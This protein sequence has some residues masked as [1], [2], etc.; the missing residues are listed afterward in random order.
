MNFRNLAI[1]SGLEFTDTELAQLE[2]D[3][4]EALARVAPIL[5]C[6]P[7]DV[8]IFPDAVNLSD[9][10]DDVHEQSISIERALGNAKRRGRYFVVPQ[11]VE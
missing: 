8:A 7:P 10:R 1:I 3:F 4:A 5:K 9:L 2:T 6:T 11:V